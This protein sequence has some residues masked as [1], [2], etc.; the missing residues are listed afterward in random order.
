M[1]DQN[2]V[3][4]LCFGFFENVQVNDFGIVIWW[5]FDNGCYLFDKFEYW[6]DIV[7]M[8]EDVGFDFFFFVDVWG[9]VDVVGECFDICFVEGFDLFWFDLVI[10]FVVFI[11]EML[12]L[13]FVVIGLI[14]FEL[15]YF[16]VC[17]MVMFDIF[18][19]G[20][21]G[22]NVVIMGMVDIVVQGF[23]V[24]M[25]GY[26]ECY[27]MVDDFMQVVYKLWEQVWDE[28]VLECDKFGCFV[29]LFKVYCIVYDGFYFCLYGYGNILCLLQGIFVLFQVGVFFVGC[30]FGG[31]Y[32]EVIFV[33]SGLVEQFCVY[34]I[35][36]CEEVVK[37]GCGVDEVKIMLVFVVVVGS[38]EE[39]VCCKYVEVVDV[40]NFDV[41][42]VFYVWFIGF[43]FLVYVLDMLMLELSI[44]FLQIQVVCFVDK[45]VGDVF[46]DW[47]VYG[48]GV[49]FIVGIL[50]QVVDWMIEFVDGV[51]FDGFL[52]VFVILL[53][54][55]VDFIE[56]VLLIFKECGVVDE[57]LLEL[58]LL[59]EC[60][61]GMLMLVFVDLYIGL[62]YWWMM[63][64]V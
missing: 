7:C 16:F 59:C 38:I 53:V 10:I 23:G 60:L 44:E 4:L 31:K 12:W 27:F 55:I 45:I 14:F 1:I 25:V 43:D 30:E 34:L 39:E 24:L 17:C 46:G 36:I 6:C 56:Y 3:K 48:V 20:C 37:N 18:L 26:D 22:W 19:G 54:L 64:C 33:G 62:Q 35:V 29:D 21:I 9:W 32:G 50:E 11:F 28:G 41:M 63:L 57:F 52:F 58:Q 49:C 51:D 2:I 40:Q 47:Y 8:V 15:L 42:V 5:Y 13:G 61:I